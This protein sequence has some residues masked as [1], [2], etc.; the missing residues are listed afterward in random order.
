M[1]KKKSDIDRDYLHRTK[2]S[3]PEQRLNWLMAAQ[4]FVAAV[5]IGKQKSKK[6]IGGVG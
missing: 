3:T 1:K 5:R 2:A 4:E 6:R